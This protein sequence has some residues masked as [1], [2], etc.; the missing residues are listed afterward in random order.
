MMA[1]A[2]CI[3]AAHGQPIAPAESVASAAARTLRLSYDFAA[4]AAYSRLPS[5]AASRRSP[6]RPFVL[7]ES[8]DSATRAL[9]CL[10]AAVYYEA[11]SEDESGQRAVAQVVL[12][13]VRHYAYPSSVCGVVFQGPMRS[14]GG[15]Q[16]SFTCDGSLRQR[17][18]QYAWDQAKRIAGDALSGRVEE[19]VGWAT[20]YHTQAVRPV[21]R[22][23]MDTAATIGRHVFYTMSGSAGAAPA[24]VR[25]SS[26]LEPGTF[27]RAGGARTPATE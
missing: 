9:E 10:T 8:S 21:W 15:C 11:R 26:S 14:G 24:F 2:S 25:R 13:R 4:L 16:F 3:P 7:P 12:N 22:R 20:H 5:A 23:A 17:R 19:T 6:A 18:D 1:P 27:R